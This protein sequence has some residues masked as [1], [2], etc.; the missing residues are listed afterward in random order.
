MTPTA[1][2]LEA[3][4]VVLGGGRGRRMGGNKLFLAV[5]GVLLL[6]RVLRRL[7]PLFP[8]IVLAVGPEDEEPLRRRL[9]SLS[10]ARPV[11]VAVDAVSGLGPLQG[12]TSALKVLKGDWAFVVGCDM[13]W[14]Q[15]AVVRSLW[16]AREAGSDVLC[17]SVDGYLEP[18]HAFYRRTCLPFAEAALA[19]GDRRLKAF[20]GDV[21]V[22]VVAEAAFLCLPGYRR[23]F[24]GI[25]T[26]S[27]LNRLADL[28]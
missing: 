24:R 26:P 5:D 27:E 23:S 18:L 2:P 15:E 10:S 12:L 7:V 8:E 1:G 20:Y 3:S 19:S 13:P 6:E 17:A 14:I 25:N 16:Q 11:A 9:P 21:R 22:T 4:A 28:L